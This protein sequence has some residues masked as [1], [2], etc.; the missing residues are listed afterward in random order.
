MSKLT[1]EQKE[2]IRIWANYNRG[3]LSH[4]DNVRRMDKKTFHQIVKLN[5]FP[6]VYAEIEKHIVSKFEEELKRK[7]KTKLT[8][9]QEAW[10]TEHKSRTRSAIE[11]EFSHEV[12][13]EPIT[14]ED[15]PE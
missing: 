14:E 3:N 7:R 2:L 11:S 15:K 1:A 5:D 4:S 13:G 10:L 9:S 12:L 8:D 6:T